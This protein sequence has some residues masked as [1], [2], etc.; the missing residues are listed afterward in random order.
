M[1]D[2][3]EKI[4]Q[5]EKEIKNIRYVSSSEL[6]VSS[7]F[8]D[9]D[10]P[11]K[12]DAVIRNRGLFTS[13]GGL[14][15]TSEA[16]VRYVLSTPSNLKITFRGGEMKY[17]IPGNNTSIVNYKLYRI[18]ADC[19]P[20]GSAIIM[21]GKI[22]FMVDSWKS[23]WKLNDAFSDIVS[24]RGP[25]ELRLLIK[26][27]VAAIKSIHSQGWVLGNSA[28]KGKVREL[29]IYVQYEEQEGNIK[30][31]YVIP[32]PLTMRMRS[33]DFTTYNENTNRMGSDW[34]IFTKMINE[35]ATDKYKA[36]LLSYFMQLFRA[37]SG[38]TKE[39]GG[40]PPESSISFSSFDEKTSRIAMNIMNEI[41]DPYKN[42]NYF[43][44]I[45][46]ML[47]VVLGN[48]GIIDSVPDVI[49]SFNDLVVAEKVRYLRTTLEYFASDPDDIKKIQE[50]IL[51]N[52]GGLNSYSGYYD[53]LVT[54]NQVGPRGKPLSLGMQF[55]LSGKREEKKQKKILMWEQRFPSKPS[56]VTGALY[57]VNYPEVIL[58]NNVAI[59]SDDFILIFNNSPLAQAMSSRSSFPEI[60]DAS[61]IR[62]FMNGKISPLEFNSELSAVSLGALASN[63]NYLGF[64]NSSIDIARRLDGLFVPGKSILDQIIMVPDIFGDAMITSAK[65]IKKN[66]A[67]YGG[68][69]E[70]RGEPRESEKREYKDVST[71]I[72]IDEMKDVYIDTYMFKGGDLVVVFFGSKFSD[73]LFG[74]L[75]DEKKIVLSPKFPSY[76][77][78]DAANIYNFMQGKMLLTAFYNAI[79][80]D[81]FKYLY[82][83]NNILGI[84]E[85]GIPML[86]T[87]NVPVIEWLAN[88]P[89]NAPGALGNL[90]LLASVYLERRTRL[91][92]IVPGVLG[93]ALSTLRQR[94]LLNSTREQKALE[95]NWEGNPLGSIWETKET[96][97]K[98]IKNVERKDE[99]VIKFIPTIGQTY[100]ELP[101]LVRGEKI[102][103][104][105]IN[106]F[107]T[108]IR[109]G[110]LYVL[111]NGSEF[112]KDVDMSIKNGVYMVSSVNMFGKQIALLNQL[113]AGEISP[114]FFYNEIPVGTVGYLYHPQNFIG[115]Y[116]DRIDY[117]KY[118]PNRRTIDVLYVENV[119]LIK[120]IIDNSVGRRN[121]L[122]RIRDFAAQ[123]IFDRTVE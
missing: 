23:M 45:M 46:E 102:P 4:A 85:T 106:L 22:A 119:P 79:S 97:V 60:K 88:L 13:L 29:P 76:I 65:A 27:A 2:I 7:G 19:I 58:G 109:S 20:K 61:L 108:K 90:R 113:L 47:Y 12:F 49:N 39:M 104:Y 80:L 36:D 117:D 81:T 16:N 123:L 74:I 69:E 42:I 118:Y 96:E 62:D 83:P 114:E 21:D 53:G 84:Y 64:Y 94:S 6:D 72:Q 59:S 122:T 71:D 73:I 82:S 66:T 43:F 98:R 92:T 103:D 107:G 50:Y 8:S 52:V 91:T 34:D 41:E 40:Y 67:R 33:G 54:T 15:S 111:F 38:E 11:E 28:K 93:K 63:S 10:I 1:S 77:E 3:K 5:Y 17:I 100:T 30:G 44:S 95:G 115:I 25:T 31:V 26:L 24:F 120:N 14:K 116:N 37:E 110:E 18:Q 55:I 105:E 48:G 86:M 99:L 51:N 35:L 56:I 68:R 87:K 70:K 57:G 9:S 101:D 75:R 78:K 32:G 121:D 112:V 89:F